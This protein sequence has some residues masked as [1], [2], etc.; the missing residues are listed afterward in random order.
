[1][2]EAQ[3]TQVG[4]GDH[5]CP[6]PRFRG[7]ESGR[8]KAAEDRKQ[9]ARDGLCLPSVVTLD[10]HRC[11]TTPLWATALL[12]KGLKRHAE[13]GRGGELSCPGVRAAASLA[14]SV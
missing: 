6:E 13:E 4:R 9:E 14:A 11:C 3:G 8:R 7:P 1:M 5:S 2:P 10:I 12:L